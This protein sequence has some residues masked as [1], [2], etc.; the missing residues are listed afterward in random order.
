MKMIVETTGKFMLVD[1]YSRDMLAHNRPCVVTG[2]EFIVSRIA[3]GQVNLLATDLVAE[4]TDKEFQAYIAASK[5][6]GKNPSREKIVALAVA[7]FTATFKTA[8]EPAEAEAEVD[9]TVDESDEAV[10]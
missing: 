7:S 4:A 5:P 6:K 1:P 3:L 2:T 8:G 10:G 9:E